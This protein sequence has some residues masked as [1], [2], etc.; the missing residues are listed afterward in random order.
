ME[1]AKRSRKKGNQNSLSQPDQNTII[2]NRINYF[3]R[4]EKSTM[5]FSSFKNH[6]PSPILGKLTD[7]S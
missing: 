2:I 4:Y 5:K 6:P 1:I 3:I 7:Q